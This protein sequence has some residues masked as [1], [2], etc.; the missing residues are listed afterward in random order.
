[1]R[2]HF[3]SRGTSSFSITQCVAM[4]LRQLAHHGRCKTREPWLRATWRGIAENTGRVTFWAEKRFNREQSVGK[5]Q[6]EARR[7]RIRDRAHHLDQQQDR[8]SPEH[9]Q[10]NAQLVDLGRQRRWQDALNLFFSVAE[11]QAKLRTSALAACAR[12]LQLH[13]ARKFFEEIPE[14]SIPDYNT[15]LSLLGRL[16]MINEVEEV[17]KEMKRHGLQPTAT[18]YGCLINAYGMVHDMAAVFGTLSDMRNA[19]LQPCAMT[20]GSVLTACSKAGEKDQAQKIIAEMR[21]TAVEPNVGH[22]TSLIC[23]CAKSKD[24]DRARA[25][26]KEMQQHGLYADLV[27]YTGLLSCIGGPG[28][29]QRSEELLEE[30]RGAGI[31]LDATFYNQVLQI[32]I[33]GGEAARA[34]QFLAE[35]TL[36][37]V[38]GNAETRLRGRQLDQLEQDSVRDAGS[39]SA[40]GPLP[41][42]WSA[43]RDPTSGQ[44]YYWQEANP[45]VTTTW[46]R[47]QQGCSG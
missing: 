42:G 12:S 29:L 37:G 45:A 25:A 2:S 23:S 27:A 5:L 21:A 35:M 34:R 39:A 22:F 10:I 41:L 19:Q 24:E 44:T 26:F 33:I 18:T 15:L 13:A 16:R 1:V 31:Q 43:T 28:A 36:Q 46:Q 9:A 3:G 17:F 11:P 20:Y 8:L 6:L 38:V 32:A 7:A 30:V 14:R 40:E 47:P 4:A